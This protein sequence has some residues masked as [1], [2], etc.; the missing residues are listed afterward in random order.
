MG[1]PSGSERIRAD[2]SGTFSQKKT[3]QIALRMWFTTPGV[4]YIFQIF[5]LCFAQGKCIEEK[6]MKSDSALC[7]G[8]R[9]PGSI[10]RVGKN[11]KPPGRSVLATATLQDY[12]EMAWIRK[13]CRT[14]Q[15]AP[16]WIG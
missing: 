15:D 5:K 16:H 10:P 7:C 3:C 11:A 14:I 6:L 13:I 8:P 12:Q 9:D 1:V 4:C 2:P